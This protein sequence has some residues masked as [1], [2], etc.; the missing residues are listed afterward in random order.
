MM[1]DDLDLQFAKLSGLSNAAQG[2]GTG[3]TMV[4]FA[5]KKVRGIIWRVK[6]VKGPKCRSQYNI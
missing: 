2:R 5:K 1:V 6:E 3:L 4:F